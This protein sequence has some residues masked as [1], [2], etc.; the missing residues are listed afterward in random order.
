MAAATA[1][2]QLRQAEGRIEVSTGTTPFT[3]YD[4]TSYRKP[5]FYPVF[6]PRQIPMT[7]NY[8]MKRVAGESDD[9]PHHKSMWIGH[10]INGVDFWS[11]KGG[12]V[13]LQKLS[14]Q[15]E[16]SRFRAWHHW[17]DDATDDVVV[18]DEVEVKFG[19]QPDY[20]LI[21][22]Q[23]RFVADGGEVT[24]ADTKEGFFALRL[25]PALRLEAD[26]QKGIPRVSGFAVNERGDTGLDVW[27]KAACWVD[28]SGEIDGIACGVAM[29][30][31]PSNPRHPTTWHARS[32]GL[33]AANPFGLH[34]FQGLP[35]GK[36][37]ISVAQGGSVDLQVSRRLAPWFGRQRSRGDVV[38]AVSG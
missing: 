33:F 30:D 37:R 28:Y 2:I 5:V 6:G 32:Y 8:P 9:H 15:E 14:I 3:S 31:H 21:D 16:R 4:Y 1:K 19:S 24:F 27:G 18:R 10:Q 22:F 17:V 36:G 34:H 11:E 12:S 26:P 35:Q 25:H 20:R 13:R 29:F 38:P 23:I 7:R